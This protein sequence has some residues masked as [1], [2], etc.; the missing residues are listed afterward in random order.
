MFHFIN[1]V[2]NRLEEKSTIGA[3]V[4]GIPAAA[5][6]PMPWSAVMATGAAILALMPT[7]EGS[8]HGDGS[9]A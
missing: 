8:H 6:L 3:I 5:V 2:R 7:S 9:D 4:A 1:Y